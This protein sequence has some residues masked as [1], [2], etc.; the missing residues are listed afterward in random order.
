MYGTGLCGPFCEEEGMTVVAAVALAVD[1][2]ATAAA[3]S[4]EEDGFIM[5]SMYSSASRRGMQ[6]VTYRTL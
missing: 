1:A 5:D 2:A 6:Y 3:A 4:E